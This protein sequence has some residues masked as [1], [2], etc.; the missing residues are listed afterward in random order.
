MDKLHE[1]H[2]SMSAKR[3]R[4]RDAVRTRLGENCLWVIPVY[5]VGGDFERVRGSSD[6]RKERGSAGGRRDESDEGGR[7][8]EVRWWGMEIKYG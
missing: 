5:H 4:G 7:E 1:C 2:F 6:S 8:R 3:D